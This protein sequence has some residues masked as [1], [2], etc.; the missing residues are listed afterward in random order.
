VISATQV[1]VGTA[2][3]LLAS[4][5][6]GTGMIR[7]TNAGTAQIF[8]GTG[9]AVTALTGAPMPSGAASTFA[10]YTSSGP[11]TLYACTASGSAAVGVV[12]MSPR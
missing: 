10:N 5:G 1:N 3:V 4:L 2:P 11:S 6:G 12:I 7:V 9:A 8:V